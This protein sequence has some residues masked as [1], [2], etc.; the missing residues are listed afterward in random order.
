M[1][2]LNQELTGLC[3]Q[4]PKL[5]NKG[6]LCVALVVTQHAK[7]KGLPLDAASLRTAEGGQVVGL[8][9]AAVQKILESHGIT[10]VL[11]EEGGR[12]SRG[13]LGMMKEYVDWLNKIHLRGNPDMQA[14]ELWWIGKVRLHFAAEGPRLNFDPGQSLTANVGDL[15]AQ[16]KAIQSNSGGANYVG[17]MLQHLVGAKLDLVLG[18]GKARHHGF[19]VADQATD[20]SGDFQINKVSIHV[21]THPTEA[22]VRKCGENINNGLKPLIV[23]TAE[24]VVGVK[25]LLENSGLHKRV[26]VVDCSQFLTVN[27]YE[28]SLFMVDECKITLTKLLE[29]YN[30]IVDECETDPVLKVN[31]GRPL[32]Y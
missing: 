31:L 13:S 10:K 19:S 23:T 16:A 17:A 22:L 3:E 7:E 9:K 26:D 27:L 4:H 12:T 18:I 30:Q 21:T 15:L 32:S 8:G 20:R 25:F 28:R 14:V 1:K 2:N 29:R 24:G 11:A 6:G 5:L